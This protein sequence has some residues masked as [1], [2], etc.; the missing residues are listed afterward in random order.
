MSDVCV[1]TELNGIG[2]VY[3]SSYRG[4]WQ[5]LVLRQ[6]DVYIWQNMHIQGFKQTLRRGFDQGI[7]NAGMFVEF[8]DDNQNTV[9]NIRICFGGLASTTL[10]ATKTA[11]AAIGM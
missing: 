8:A 5:S 10:P 3:T 4:I 1:A 9:K 2:L 6:C 7:V 11:K